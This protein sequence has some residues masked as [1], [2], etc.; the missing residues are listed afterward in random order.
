MATAVLRVLVQVT[1]FGATFTLGA[2]SLDADAATVRERVRAYANGDRT[3]V[4]V[5]VRYPDGFLGDVM[6]EMAAIPSGETR[7]YG[8][9]AAAL[10]TAP[11]AVGQA[12]GRNPVP[13]VVPCHRVVG[14]DSL[15]GYSIDAPDPLAVKRRL[16]VHEGALDDDV[17]ALDDE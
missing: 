17:G 12:C 14:A 5:P 16:L 7:S 10:D 1:A 11:V 4:D 13:L 3:D 6:R 2:S 15:G 8:D 9:V